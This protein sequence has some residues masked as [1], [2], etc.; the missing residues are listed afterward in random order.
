MHDT[1]IYIYK[2][3]T[4]T[5]VLCIMYVHNAL[6]DLVHMYLTVHSFNQ[7]HVLNTVIIISMYVCIS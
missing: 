4:H 1:F 3:T 6:V 5:Y 7:M 2:C